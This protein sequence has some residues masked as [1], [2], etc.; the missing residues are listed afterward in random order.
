MLTGYGV[1]HWPKGRAKSVAKWLRRLA[2]EMEKDHKVFNHSRF[3]A[4]YMK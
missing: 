1:G 3:V 4:R 2:S